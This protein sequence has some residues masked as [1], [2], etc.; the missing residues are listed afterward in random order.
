MVPKEKD[1]IKLNGETCILGTLLT[2]TSHTKQVRRALS[3]RIF[4]VLVVIPLFQPGQWSANKNAQTDNGWILKIL[5]RGSGDDIRTEK[6]TIG[7]EKK[8][9][10]KRGKRERPFFLFSIGFKNKGADLFLSSK[11]IIFRTPFFCILIF[12]KAFK[13]H[14]RKTLRD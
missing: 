10:R 6:I 2:D 12:R 13:K 5:K 1:K 4:F 7:E 9:K 11:K 3:W 14:K 8:R